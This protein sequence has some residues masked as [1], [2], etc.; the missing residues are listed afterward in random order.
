MQTRSN[1]K[2]AAYLSFG[3]FVL[4]LLASV[5]Y[6]KERMFFAD[7]AHI[8][9]SAIN[10]QA[11]QIQQYR[12]GAF[13]TQL[14][15]VLGAKLGLPLKVILIAYSASFHLFYLLVAALLLFVFRAYRL[16]VLYAFY[17]ALVT[18]HTFFWPNNE[19]HQG[20]AYMFLLFPL[21]SFSGQKKYPLWLSAAILVLLGTTAVFCHPLVIPPFI[22]LWVYLIYEKEEWYFNRDQTIILSIVAAVIILAKLYVSNNYAGYDSGLLTGVNQMD[23]DNLLSV[24]SS[25]LAKAIYWHV[26]V[27]YWI[28]PLISLAGIVTLL[29]KR[30]YLLAGWTLACA[31]VYFVLLCL[32]FHGYNE[33]ITESELMPGII[34]CTAPFVFVT[35]RLLRPELA[36]LLVLLIFVL[37]CAKFEGARAHFRSRLDHLS[38]L[39]DKMNRQGISKLVLVKP[40]SR[41]DDWR[42]LVEWGFPAETALFSAYT[43]G[44]RVR[45]IVVL[46]QSELQHRLPKNST[47]IMT[48]YETWPLAKVNRRYLSFDT[49]GPYVVM[50]YDEFIRP[51]GQAAHSR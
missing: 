8:V 5:Y 32:T 29:F 25:P 34:I 36:A 40:D 21:L 6:Y 47:D 11:L 43:S 3:L 10:E 2:L 12:F 39:L 44:G 41:P 18:T 50:A 16:L 28:L 42:W 48:C 17:W 51:P 4:M 13:I 9:F 14:V 38:D 31:L 7:A 35:L 27:N 46:K 23:A 30:H 22:F 49:T 24:F 1:L 20:I 15:P 37:R 19:V 45:Q 33:F 26:P